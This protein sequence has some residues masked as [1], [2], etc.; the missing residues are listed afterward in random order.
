M[1]KSA[2]AFRSLFLPSLDDEA[3]GLV[4]E[5]LDSLLLGDFLGAISD[6]GHFL[7]P[8]LFTV[9]DFDGLEAGQSFER[10]TDALFASASCDAGHAGDVG[11]LLSQRRGGEGKDRQG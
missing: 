11:D 1:K 6:N 7:G 5:A 9:F 2:S 10:R 8:R 3:L 4:S